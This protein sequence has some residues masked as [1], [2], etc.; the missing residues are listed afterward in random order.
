MLPSQ[1]WLFIFLLD[2]VTVLQYS[3]SSIHSFHFSLRKGTE[4][5]TIFDSLEMIVKKN[6]RSNLF[7]SLLCTQIYIFIKHSSIVRIEREHLIFVF[8]RWRKIIARERERESES[9][10]AIRSSNSRGLFLLDHKLYKG[11]KINSAKCK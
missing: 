4:K 9:K 5:E 6:T 8:I 2:D 3:S 1:L 10:N 11:R 7:D